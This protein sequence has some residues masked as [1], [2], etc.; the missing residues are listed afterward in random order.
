MGTKNAHF[1]NEYD[2]HTS[3]ENHEESDYDLDVDLFD[4][5]VLITCFICYSSPSFLR[6]IRLP[7]KVSCSILAVEH[8]GL[9][10]QIVEVFH[11][12][13]LFQCRMS[14]CTHDEDTSL[15]K[16]LIT[17]KKQYARNVSQGSPI[18]ATS[19][20]VPQCI[21]YSVKF[22]CMFQNTNHT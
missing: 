20:K 2:I 11:E 16:N 19:S 8:F 22:P 5:L 21:Q 17:G 3:S 4:H 18:L 7:K 14:F 10:C 1:D 6:H 9:K 12:A 13:G 15:R